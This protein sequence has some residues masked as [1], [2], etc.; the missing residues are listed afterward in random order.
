MTIADPRIATKLVHGKLYTSTVYV[1]YIMFSV[2][3]PAQHALCLMSSHSYFLV[4]PEWPLQLKVS[5]H[6]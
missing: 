1:L 2:S 4:K 6:L 5:M 3:Q